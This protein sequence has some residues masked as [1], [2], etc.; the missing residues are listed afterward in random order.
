MSMKKVLWL[1]IVLVFA[2]SAPAGASPLALQAKGDAFPASILTS[3]QGTQ[4]G[5]GLA[6]PVQP[7]KEELE[8]LNEQLRELLAQ[9]SPDA[10]AIGNL[11]IQ[12]K[13]LQE[14]I[15]AEAKDKVIEY[16][17]LTSDQVAQWDALVETRNQTVQPLRE[18]IEALNKRLRELL[19]Q[20][21]PDA[22]AIGNLM[23]QVNGFMNDIKAATDAYI[24]AFKGI[25]TEDQIIKLDTVRKA[26]RFG[27]GFMRD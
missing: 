24:E 23:I 22:T 19:A 3:E 13:G 25:L 27:N 15:K 14:Q 5:G 18:K 1:F 9:S 4:P 21:S 7:L 6:I 20:S 10:T 11:M 16:L 17:A 2:L 12:I 26:E 8:A